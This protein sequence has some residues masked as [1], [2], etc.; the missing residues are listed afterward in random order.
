MAKL[1]YQK[2]YTIS[3]CS[4]NI[5]RVAKAGVQ[6]VTL[7]V[8]WLANV[9]KGGTITVKDVQCWGLRFSCRH[10]TFTV[11]PIGDNKIAPGTQKWRT[12][13]VLIYGVYK[14]LQ[15]KNWNA[16]LHQVCILPEALHSHNL[17]QKH[18]T[19]SALHGSTH[20]AYMFTLYPVPH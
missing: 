10:C 9:I 14:N 3:I 13:T 18:C 1:Q 4:A 7:D 12:H 11:H 15:G 17:A 8:I 5:Y 2:W 6:R 16:A 20:S 19:F